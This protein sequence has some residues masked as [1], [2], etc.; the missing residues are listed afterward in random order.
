M[1]GKVGIES[2]NF[3]QTKADV[4]LGAWQRT[5]DNYGILKTKPLNL[6]YDKLI[7]GVYENQEIEINELTHECHNATKRAKN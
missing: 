2:S 6:Y 5:F 7:E 4:I 1:A 3:K